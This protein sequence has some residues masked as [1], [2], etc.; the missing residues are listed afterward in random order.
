MLEPLF[1][2]NLACAGCGKIQHPGRNPATPS[3]ARAVLCARPTNAARRSSRSP[4]ASRCCIRRSTRSSPAWSPARSTSISAPTPSSSKNRC[5]GFK[6]S[7]YLAFSVHLDGPREEHDHAVC[8]DGHLRHRRAGDP[9]GAGRAAF[10][11][12]PTPRS[13]TAPIP[14]GCA[15]FFDE[16]MD[17]G[18]EGMMI[19]PG[20]SYD[21]APD[22][23]HF[24]A[25]RADDAACSAAVLAQRQAHAGEFN[26]TPLFLE[27]LQRQLRPGM[28]ALGQP[29][30]QHLRLAAAL[31]PARRRLLRDVSRADGDD[32]LG[33]LRPRQRQ[34]KCRDCM[35]HCGYEPTAVA[36]TFNSLRGFVA[37]AR[38]T[39]FGAK[40]NRTQRVDVAKLHRSPTKPVLHQI[41]TLQP[42][43]SDQ[44]EA[45]IQSS[46]RQSRKDEMPTASP[47]G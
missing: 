34:P 21:K 27:F 39:L 46:S 24:L 10:A 41:V 1:R 2:C 30:L 7:K 29:D 8:R 3:D 19:S 11:S 36:A 25:P 22:Q 15:T 23:D 16:L 47:L 14:S 4:A 43:P 33:P 17:L 18:V 31:L 35:V 13:S 42:R 9:R 37:T 44:V 12:R 20:Y 28:H 26:Q 5:R 6:P 32:R 45:R 38:L 40:R